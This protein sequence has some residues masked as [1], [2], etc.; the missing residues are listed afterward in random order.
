PSGRT[1]KQAIRNI[2]NPQGS[3]AQDKGR[4]KNKRFNPNKI[5]KAPPRRQ[6]NTEKART[7]GKL[8]AP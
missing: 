3:A 4:T 6:K 2:P 1:K 8:R 5:R 7:A